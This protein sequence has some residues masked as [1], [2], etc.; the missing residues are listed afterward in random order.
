MIITNSR[1]ALVGYFITSYPTRAH[2]I[3]VKYPDDGIRG[4]MSVERSRILSDSVR[5]DLASSG[6]TANDDKSMW[7][8]THKLV[9]LE[10]ILDFGEG[11]IQIAEFRILKFKSFLVSCLQNNQFIARDLASVTEQFISMACAVGNVTRLFRRNCY[12]AIECR[13]S[14]DQLLHVSPVVRYEL[15]FWLNNIDFI[16]GK[17]MSPKSSA[18]G[19]VYYD[20]S[21]SGFR[22]LL[23]AVWPG[24][25]VRCLLP[26]GNADQL[27]F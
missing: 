8:P 11:L 25:S 22:R 18:V 15:S 21:D 19:V 7:E 26:R 23:R 6:S 20:A 27:F 16:N 17:V 2:G 14:L 3:I 1:Y 12:A 4:D 13:S 10:S 5:Q 24:F 9:F